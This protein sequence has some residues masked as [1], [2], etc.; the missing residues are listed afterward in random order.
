MKRA[1]LINNLNFQMKSFVAA[2]ALAA[3]AFS[4]A[5]FSYDYKDGGKTWATQATCSGASC[6]DTPN[7][8]G[9]GKEQSPIDFP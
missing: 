1:D 3:T 4:S 6:A 2:C 9:T 7:V 8:C 5:S